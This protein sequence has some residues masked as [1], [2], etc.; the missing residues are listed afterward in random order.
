[1]QIR[2]HLATDPDAADIGAH[3][4]LSAME[5]FRESGLFLPEPLRP[6]LFTPMWATGMLH[7]LGAWDEQIMV[8]CR[9][10][11][12]A[13]CIF[14]GDLKVAS[15]VSLFVA[16]SARSRGIASQLM[17]FGD[18]MLKSK[19]VVISTVQAVGNHTPSQAEGYR[20]AAATWERR[21]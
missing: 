21:L 8:G 15:T 18:E 20:P 3:A 19:G 10:I 4:F 1:M 17:K 12:V 9:V 11:V 6:D 14:N 5:A 16:P 7:I 2:A 13:P